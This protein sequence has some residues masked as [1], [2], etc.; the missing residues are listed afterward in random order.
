MKAGAGCLPRPGSCTE[1]ILGEVKGLADYPH[2]SFR[3]GL[4]L[5]WVQTC[6]HT[7]SSTFYFCG[8]FLSLVPDRHFWLTA[9]PDFRVLEAVWDLG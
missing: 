6:T 9:S 2:A 1:G 8:F 5:F 7:L 3:A 4:Q